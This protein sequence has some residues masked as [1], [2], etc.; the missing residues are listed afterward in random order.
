MIT[1]MVTGHRP[2]KLFG[3]RFCEDYAPLSAAIVKAA[4]RLI[5]KNPGEKHFCFISGGAQGA[6][7]TFFW[8]IN[9]LKRLLDD[10]APGIYIIENIVHVPFPG[11]EDRWAAYGPF[12]KADYR[13]MLNI[14]DKVIYVRDTKPD[15][16]KDVVKALYA[17]NDSMIAASDVVISVCRDPHEHKGGT[18]H[19]TKRAIQ[20]NKLVCRIDPMTNEFS[21][22]HRP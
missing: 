22:M 5:E 21:V 7:Q 18:A 9:T 17:R 19:A 12:S 20:A 14:A 6:D 11:Q 16:Y 8:S 10:K 15:D 13:D 4:L 2:N 3:Y 1:C